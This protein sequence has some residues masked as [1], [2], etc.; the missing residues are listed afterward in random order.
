MAAADLLALGA[1]TLGESGARP[2]HSRIRPAWPGAVLAGPAYTARCPAGDN[3]AIHVATARAPVGSVLVVDASQDLERGNWGEVLAT[4]ALTRRL[5]G[6]VIEGGVRDV[7]A[8][9]AHG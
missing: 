5:R 4:Q 2:M 1:A 9:E 8:L 7:A 3:K 6:L